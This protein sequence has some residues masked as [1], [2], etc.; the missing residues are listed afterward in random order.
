MLPTKAETQLKLG[1][2]DVQKYT[3]AHGPF[4]DPAE[5]EE[6]TTSLV[7]SYTYSGKPF[8]GLVVMTP[9]YDESSKLEEKIEK[10][11]ATLKPAK[12]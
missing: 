9:T 10:V 5:A 11:L 12:K 4:N 3:V 8:E 6:A 1:G 7:T 2:Y